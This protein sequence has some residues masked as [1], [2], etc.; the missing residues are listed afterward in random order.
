PPDAFRPAFCDRAQRI[1]LARN[2]KRELLPSLAGTKSTPAV[3][4]YVRFTQRPWVGTCCLGFEEPLANMPQDGLEYARVTGISALLLCTDLAPWLKEPLLVNYV[5]VGID[6]G[7]MV[8]AGHPGWA[9]WGGNG[10]GRKLPIIVAGMLLGDESLANITRYLPRVS[11]GEDEQTAD[12]PSWTGASVVFAGHSG[13]DASTGAGRDRGKGWGPYEHMPP[14]EWK[15]G[16]NTSEGYRRCCTSVGW[17]AQALVLRLLHAERTWNHPSF[18]DYVDRWMYEDDSK[19]IQTIKAA[20]GRDY[21]RDWSRQGQ[22]WD[23]FV[24]EM[25]ATY[26][27]TVPAPRDGWKHPHDDRLYRAAIQKMKAE[28]AK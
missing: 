24:D 16:Q 15:D 20:T 11:F 12:G 1:Y 17:V 14:S 5:Q 21:N 23:A 22:A 27:D 28:A 9:A 13:I 25:W 7:G 4:L 10:S 18:F 26:R 3:D 6:L 19:S 2:L 8:R